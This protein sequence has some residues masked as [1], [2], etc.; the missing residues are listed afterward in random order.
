MSRYSNQKRAKRA[1]S[2][3]AAPSI[4]QAASKPGAG[5]AAMSDVKQRKDWM[6]SAITLVDPASFAEHLVGWLEATAYLRARSEAATSKDQILSLSAADFD[7]APVRAVADDAVFAFC[8]A[9]ALNADRPAVEKLESLLAERFG[10]NFPGIAAL[11]CCLRGTAT[12]DALDTTAGAFVKDML[13]AKAF[14][15][16]DIWNAG[17]RFL[18][19]ARQSNFGQELIAA[20]AKWH[21]DRWG[22]IITQQLFNLTRPRATVPPIEE[23]LGDSRNDQAFIACLLIAATGAV[24]LELD[25]AYRAHLQGLARRS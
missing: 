17:L 23:M 5:P 24:D 15:P 21:R 7:K 14:D 1:A 12:G 25:E 9:A 19:K 18:E 16:R 4:A 6:N 2:S 13:D 8:I 3:A 20:L 11:E 10:Q 22:H